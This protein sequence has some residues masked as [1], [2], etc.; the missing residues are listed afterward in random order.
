[1]KFVHVLVEGQTEETFLR[2][3]LNP[4]LQDYDVFLT[5][6]IIT[7]KHVNTGKDF[8]GGGSDYKKIRNDLCRLL[9]DNS[10]AA[11]T[12]MI[13][14][15]GLP[16]D[17]PGKSTIQGN[18]C[19]DRVSY[20]EEQFAMDIKKERFIPFLVLHEFEAYLFTLPECLVDAFPELGDK[21]KKSLCKLKKIL[22]HQKRLMVEKRLILRHVLTG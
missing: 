6:K 4:Y 9:G 3:V 10:V 20:L 1:M 8:K 15:Y 2:N 11:V 13:D 5:A 21:E 7:T 17:F 22:I 16:A 14:Y 18:N 12:T 19:F